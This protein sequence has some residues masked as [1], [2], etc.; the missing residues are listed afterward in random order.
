MVLYVIFPSSRYVSESCVDTEG[1]RD[2]GAVF[3]CEVIAL[4]PARELTVP[5]LPRST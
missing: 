4:N 3:V 2:L 1:S 5:I